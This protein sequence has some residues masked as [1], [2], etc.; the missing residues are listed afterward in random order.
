MLANMTVIS[1]IETTPSRTR[2]L[3]SVTTYHRFSYSRRRIARLSARWNA[4]STRITSAIADTPRVPIDERCGT[5]DD[6]ATKTA[7]TTMIGSI[8]TAVLIVHRTKR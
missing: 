2:R 4:T 3:R 1:W 5:I 8:E 6:T 7:A